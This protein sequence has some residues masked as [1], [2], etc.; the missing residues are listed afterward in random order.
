MASP[1]T[2]KPYYEA[3]DLAALLVNPKVKHAALVAAG[4][5]ESPDLRSSGRLRSPELSRHRSQATASGTEAAS[6][7]LFSLLREAVNAHTDV[8]RAA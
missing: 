6:N 1:E 3:D 8:A 5:G 2:K 7:A 4:G